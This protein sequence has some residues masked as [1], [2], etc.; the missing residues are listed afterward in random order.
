MS[1]IPGPGKFEGNPSLQVSEDLYGLC[2]NSWFNESFGDVSEIGIWEA[3]FLNL[4][5]EGTPKSYI[6]VENEQGFFSYNAYDT[7]DE[8]Y[9]KYFADLAAFES[10]YANGVNL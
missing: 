1:D 10:H 4:T 6:V 3:L 5:I 9:S 2:G 7:E 8:A